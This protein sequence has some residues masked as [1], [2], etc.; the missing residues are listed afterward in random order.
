MCQIRA[1]QTGRVT[2]LV[3]GSGTD[4][5]QWG[6]V[7]AAVAGAGDG[8]EVAGTAEVLGGAEGLGA[9]GCF[10]GDRSESSFCSERDDLPPYP[11]GSAARRF[12]M[13]TAS[14]HRFRSVSVSLSR[15][16]AVPS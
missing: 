2:G 13:S 16:R 15:Q 8:A 3:P 5:V 11:L 14:D 6:A 1:R 12:R 4:G 7:P 9:D 10:V